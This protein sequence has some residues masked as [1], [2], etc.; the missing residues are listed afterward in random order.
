[1]RIT[2][3]KQQNIKNEIEQKILPWRSPAQQETPKDGWLKSIRISLGM[4]SRQ[5]AAK[6]GL[7][8]AGLVRLE[9]REVKGT[10]SLD[11]ISKAA[12]AMNCRLVYAIIPEEKYQTLE[13]IIEEQN[14]Q[15]A[16]AVDPADQLQQQRM[17]T[18]QKVKNIVSQLKDQLD[19]NM[20][21]L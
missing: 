19:S 7:D 6:M 17:V 4:T 9:E 13:A 11:S 3:D 15:K 8:H 20:W 5:L 21:D 2:K 10:A 16:V 14:R 12:K 1:M 18:Q